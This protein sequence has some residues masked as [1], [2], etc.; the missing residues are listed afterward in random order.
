[1]FNFVRLS[2]GGPARLAGP[3][4]EVRIVAELG[5]RLK[6]SGGPVDWEQMAE[7]GRI[8]QAIARIIPGWEKIGQIDA[9]RQEFEI[10]GRR[11][12][13]PKFPTSSGRASLQVHSLPPLA[14]SD[15]Q[16]RLMTV[17]SE[18]QFNTVVYE[19]YDLYRGQDRRDVV[20]VH[21]TDLAA[22]GITNGQRVTVASETGALSNIIARAYDR[23]RAGNVLMYFPE[24][25]VL[26][27]R[28]VDPASRTP[29]FKNVLVT[30]EP[31]P[32]R[33]GE[34]V[35]SNGYGGV[36]TPAAAGPSSRDQ[37]RAC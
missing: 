9:T 15:G 1:M 31:M 32:A 3:R 27:P 37:M 29:A 6:G 16:L 12:S 28:K 11:I 22:R 8:R 35:A 13:E 7:T 26:V 30:L 10:A 23:I 2:D 34:A 5:R 18:G 36:Y 25:N 14:G 33:P 24:A 21:P 19:D 4:S 17:R 20:L